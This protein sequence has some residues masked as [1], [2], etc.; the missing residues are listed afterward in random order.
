MEPFRFPGLPTRVVFGHGT[1]AK[2]GDEMERLGRKRAVVLATPPQRGQAEALAALL[3]DRAAGVI[4][5][6]VMHTPVAVTDGALAQ[7][8]ALD[9]DCL[10]AVGGGSTTGLSKALAL[11]TDLDQIVVP[12]TYAGSEMTPILGETRDGTKTTQKSPKILPEVVVYDVDLTLGLPVALS[13]TSGMNAIAH[14]VEALY[15]EDRNPI[16]SLMAEEAIRALARALPVIVADPQDRAARSDAL[17]GAWLAGACLGTVGMALHHKLCHVLG[18]TFDLPHA[19]THTV[20][21][22]HAV[23]YNAPAVPDAMARVA[24]ALGAS[25][26]AQGLYDLAARLG[27]PTALE[28]LGMPEAGLER[29]ADAAVAS[30]YPNPRSLAR[31]GIRRLLDDAYHGRRPDAA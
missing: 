22:P 18:G 9:A 28:A 27:A 19:E 23:A 21:L 2:V 30:P 20:V 26:A 14:A 29:A 8:R 6:A 15:A 3:G 17:Y 16:V 4:A 7:L 1:L 24:R 10:V 25:S 11:R 13:A 12:T 5:D 31:D